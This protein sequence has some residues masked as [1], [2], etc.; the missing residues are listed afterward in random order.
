MSGEMFSWLSVLSCHLLSHQKFNLA[1]FGYL[2]H[3]AVRHLYFFQGFQERFVV[4]C[5]W[6]GQ[7]QKLAMVYWA[8]QETLQDLGYSLCP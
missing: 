2:N 3:E 4:K 6:L 7:S 8:K 5:H 1:V